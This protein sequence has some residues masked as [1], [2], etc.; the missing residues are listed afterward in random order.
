VTTLDDGRSIE[1]KGAPIVDRRVERG[2]ATRDRL[3]AVAT[4]LFAERGFDATSIE[5]VLAAADVS[6]G[7]LYHHFPS[8]EA[9]FEA[10]L[11]AVE[12]R[13]GAAAVAA[14]AA[15]GARTARDRLHAGCLAWIRLAAEPDVRR[16][17]LIDAP[18]VVGWRRWREIEEDAPLGLLKGVLELAADEG[19]L[20]P[21][22]VDVYAHMVLATLN[23]LALYVA[24]AD[25]PAGAQR[26]AQAAVDDYLA[27]LFP[28]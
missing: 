27:R 13:V 8:K 11:L 17:V 5:A 4:K 25:D 22:L 16:I 18:S 2:R 7:S 12:A 28:R 9:L 24:R 15:R 6:R 20:D 1:E 14:G 23:E 10:V 3:I 21:A 19:A 26:V